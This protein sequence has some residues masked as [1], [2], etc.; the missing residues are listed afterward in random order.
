MSPG[1]S[2]TPVCQQVAEAGTAI[3]MVLGQM[4]RRGGTKA[5]PVWL[6]LLLM[7]P[8]APPGLL[9]TESLRPQNHP[10]AAPAWPLALFV[11]MTST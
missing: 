4:S 2:T 1:T 10:E 9:T 7:V 3:A 11:F 6:Q 8:Q 5:F